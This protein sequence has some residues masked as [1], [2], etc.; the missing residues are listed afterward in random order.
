MAI[1]CHGIADRAGPA[2]RHFGTAGAH[3]KLG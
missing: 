3:Q 2:D 1:G